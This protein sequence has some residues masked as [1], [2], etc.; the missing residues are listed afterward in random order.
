MWQVDE[1]NLITK[2]VYVSLEYVHDTLEYV[3]VSLQY[4]YEPP[5]Y[6]Y[7]PL[8]YV[9]EALEHVYLPSEYVYGVMEHVWP[10]AAYVRSGVHPGFLPAGVAQVVEL[11][12]PRRVAPCRA[13]QRTVRAPFRPPGASR[14][15]L[16][17]G[18]IRAGSRLS[19]NDVVEKGP[20]IGK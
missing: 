10:P 13:A 9:Y 19:R 11:V 3:Y 15:S 8:E 1:I 4:V 2:Y 7:L 5:E 17:A 18:E 6:V 20:P 16:I 14:I 12:A